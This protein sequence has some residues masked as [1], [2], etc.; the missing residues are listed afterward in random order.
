LLFRLVLAMVAAAGTVSAQNTEVQKG[1]DLFLYFCAEC[2]GKDAR[3]I[4]PIA[5]ML[6][7]EPPELTS[8]AERNGG[9][10]PTESVAMQ[11]D[12]RTSL[13]SHGDMPVFG[14]YLVS[15]QSVA[16]KLPNGQ[17]MMVSQHLANLIA[18]L[19]AVQFEPK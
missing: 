1:Q 18:Y 17:P 9:K 4:G 14:P 3:S 8:L 13:A 11:I 19:Q 12:G 5:E 2:H 15:D 10:F 6:A 7:I 16:I